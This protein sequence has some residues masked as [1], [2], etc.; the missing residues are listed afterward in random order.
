MATGF[1]RVLYKVASARF[2]RMMPCVEREAARLFQ[3]RFRVS[4]FGVWWALIM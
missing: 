2:N 1:L 3:G 4:G